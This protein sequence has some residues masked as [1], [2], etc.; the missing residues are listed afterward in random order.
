MPALNTFITVEGFVT[1]F[2]VKD[3]TLVI[4]DIHISVDN[5]ALPSIGKVNISQAPPPRG[6]GLC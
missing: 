6:P 1:Q 3:G 4:G 2:D 5:L